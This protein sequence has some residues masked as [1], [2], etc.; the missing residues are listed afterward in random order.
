M[1]EALK[2]FIVYEL[3]TTSRVVEARDVEE[4]Y[5]K[6]EPAPRRGLNL[7]NWHVV[8]AVVNYEPRK[9]PDANDLGIDPDL[10]SFR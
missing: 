2:K 7:S 6:S 1:A 5:R 9:A 3:W 10:A 4:A 8:E